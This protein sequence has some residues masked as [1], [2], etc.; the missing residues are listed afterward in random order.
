[1]VP[2][3][4][5][6]QPSP[7][8]TE[9]GQP[10]YPE[11]TFASRPAR[12]SRRARRR[13]RKEAKR[14]A[15][16]RRTHEK[17]LGLETPAPASPAKRSSGS[18]RQ[19]QT[20]TSTGPAPGP[21]AVA[22]SRTAVLVREAATGRDLADVPLTPPTAGNG[23]LAVFK[24]RYLLKLLVK[25][26]ISAR[27]AGSFLGLLWSYIGPLCQF[28][29]YWF[30]IGV[31]LSLHDRIENFGIHIFAGLVVV[32]FFTETFAAG[33]RSIVRNKAV[34]VKLALPR[35]MFP[36]ASM[37]VSLFHVFPQLVILTVACLAYGWMPDAA[38]MAAL[39]LALLIAMLLGTGCALL[40]SAANVYFRDFSNVVSILQMFVRFSVPMI[41]P[42][43]IVAD[44]FG[45]AAQYYLW[46]PLADCVLLVQ[47]A[48]WVGTTSDPAHSAETDLP[49]DLFVW[50]GT[51]VGVGFI[52]LVIGQLVFSRLETRIPERL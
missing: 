8:A 20:A 3:A 41:Y 10:V 26:E 49:A 36:V 32:H 1:V 40:F 39:L 27:Y 21:A 38:G 17:A 15:K 9:W 14:T 50:G 25:R 51:M 7:P 46:N 24:K 18:R 43:S 48:F 22:G 45:S 34:I 29:V 12:L 11:P 37:L 52:V 44:R 19:K 16:A 5:P 31:I 35:E 47:R 2:A 6:A 23:F 13:L 4:A 42:Y 30:V 28:F 33:T